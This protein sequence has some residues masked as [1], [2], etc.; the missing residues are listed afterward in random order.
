MIGRRAATVWSIGPCQSPE[1][2]PLGELGEEDVDRLVEGED[3][4]LDEQRRA[5]GGHR[6]GHRA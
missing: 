5:E 1:H 6:L 3:P 2:L 4:L